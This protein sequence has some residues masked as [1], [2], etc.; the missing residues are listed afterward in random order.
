MSKRCVVTELLVEHCAHCCPKSRGHAD[1][2]DEPAEHVGPW[3]AARY[4]GECS[5]CGERFEEFDQIRGD[6]ERG[7]LAQCCGG[8]A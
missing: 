8:D 6:G 1:P 5:G 7:Y 3:F 4:R 2:F